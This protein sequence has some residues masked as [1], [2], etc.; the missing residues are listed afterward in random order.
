RR[1]AS[2]ATT[3][4]CSTA[5]FGSMPKTRS[6]RVRVP[7]DAPDRFRTGASMLACPPACLGLPNHDQPARG[8]GDRALDRQEVALRIYSDNLEILHR[9]AVSA[10]AP[11]HA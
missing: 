4:W 9:H 11:S 7:T 2:W 1:L 10:H 8:S 6:S 5:R 3:A